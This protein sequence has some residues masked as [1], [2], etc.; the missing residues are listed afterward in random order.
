MSSPARIFLGDGGSMPIGFTVAALVTIGTSDAALEWRSLAV[1][2]LLVGIPAVDTALVILSRKRRGVPVVTA[3]RDHLTHRTLAP[4]R[5]AQA[6][7]LTL[8]AVQAV[9]SALALVAVRGNSVLIVAAVAVYLMA[10][11]TAIALLDAREPTTDAPPDPRS[12]PREPVTDPALRPVALGALL[13]VA[14]GLLFGLSPF[15]SGYYDSGTWVPA[16]LALAALVAAGAIARPPDLTATATVALVALGGLGLWALAS[17]LW[18]D[19]IQQAVTEGNRLLGYGL[20]LGVLLIAMRVRARAAWAFGAFAVGA[21]VVAGDTLVDMLGDDPAHVFVAGRLD[22]PL[23]YINGQASFF[24]I[25]LWICVA[26]AEQRRRPLLAAAGLGATTLLGC[27]LVLSQSRGVM[28]AAG[29]TIVLVL[30]LVPGRLRRA[31]ALLVAGAGVGVA[32]PVLIDV[33]SSRAGGVVDASAVH[34]AGRATLLA[35]VATAVLWG[36]VSFAS[37]H[38]GPRLPALRRSAAALLGV[39]LVAGSL[40]AV[41]NQATVRETIGDQYTAFVKQRIEPQGSAA[42]GGSSRLISGAGNRY[43]YWRIAWDAWKDEPLAGT[44]AGAY[45]ERYFVERATTESIRQPHSLGLQTL[46][47][48]GIVGAALLLILLGAL[49][50]GAR[51]V[52]ASA[53]DS[54]GARFVAVAATGSLGAWLVHTSVDWM[55]LLPGLTGIA[56]V[57]AAALLVRPAERDPA[58]GAR[59]RRPI[60][61]RRLVPAIG[62]ALVIAVAAVSLSRQGLTEHYT[63]R[64]Q[65]ALAARPADALVEADRA[66]RLDREA[67]D[68]YYV[69]SAALARFGRGTAARGVLLE[70][71]RREPRDFVTWILLGDLAVRMGDLD[72]ARANYGR[73]LK[74]NPREPSLRRLVADPAA[75]LR[76]PERE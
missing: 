75:V 61:A 43:D 44:G 49:G 11:G 16:G 50:L 15:F 2:L 27:L 3:G 19:S 63:T 68:A 9:V 7:A 4:L 60:A 40:V 30:A 48:L 13:L 57:G 72:A 22:G 10:A 39:V 25:A 38:A 41:A 28:L 58:A 64:G 42:V 35:A 46:S 70:A 24:L 20:L 47:E 52:A 62:V 67:I 29:V 26:V 8:G 12:R 32:T 34:A 69:K 5:T 18:A 23:G 45:P 73:A 51:R 36:A 33:Y 6:V 31:W 54:T 74:L 55:H 66:L 21:L 59:P 1:G 71:S 65:D 53:R 17:L 56:L 76:R 14:L 37:A